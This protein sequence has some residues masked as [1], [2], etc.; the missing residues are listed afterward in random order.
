[1]GRVASEA[2]GGD[3]LT[4]AELYAPDLDGGE[5]DIETYI[6]PLA[7]DETPPYL[8]DVWNGAMALLD[9]YDAGDPETIAYLDGDGDEG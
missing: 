1:V 8:R 4:E 9:K 5:V 7:G 3:A 2:K 6:C